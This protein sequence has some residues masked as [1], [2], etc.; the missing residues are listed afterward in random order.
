MEEANRPKI[1]PLKFRLPKPMPPSET[2]PAPVNGEKRKREEQQDSPIKKAKSPPSSLPNQPNMPVTMNGTA[3]PVAPRVMPG[4]LPPTSAAPMNGYGPMPTYQSQPAANIAMHQSPSKPPQAVYQPPIAVGQPMRPIQPGTQPL[5]ITQHYPPGIPPNTHSSPQSF[6]SQRPVSSSSMQGTRHSPI[7]NRPSMSPTQGNPDVG[8]LA[9]F[10]PTQ[11]TGTLPSTP[12]G[13]RIQNNL[14]SGS[15][16][17]VGAP[18]N[19]SPTVSFSSTATPHQNNSFSHTPT[20]NRYS[21]GMPMSGR[22]PTK[23]S[24]PRPPSFNE[25]GNAATVLPPVQRLQPSPK[26]MGR[27]SPDA[28]IPPPV[29]NMTP[30][31]DDRRRREEQLAAQQ[32][33]QPQPQHAL[34]QNIPSLT[35]TQP[36]QQRGLPQN[37]PPLS[38]TQPQQQP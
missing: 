17:P 38:S 19:Q 16:Y 26:L 1:P 2:T 18:P 24:P 8:P 5:N 20:P 12:F 7:Q 9:G 28:P 37:I 6:N 31:Q 25:L 21:P 10:P 34:P 33:Q 35:S 32:A 29:K 4:Q 27:S 30:E 23:H 13:A 11:P 15:P 3:V 14:N 36:Q 22:S